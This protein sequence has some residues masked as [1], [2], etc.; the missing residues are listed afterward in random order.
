MDRSQQREWG[1]GIRVDVPVTQALDAWRRGRVPFGNALL[2]LVLLILVAAA[3]FSGCGNGK[4]SN[5]D[6]D[7][8]TPGDRNPIPAKLTLKEGPPL[9]PPT[10]LL[11]SGQGLPNEVLDAGFDK[12]GNLWAASTS[13]IFVRRHGLG[14][15][16]SFGSADGLKGE[17]VLSIGGG[18]ADTAWVG[19]RGEGDSDEDPEWM[20]MSGGVSR[21]ILDGA[22]IKV[23]HYNLI[24]PPGLYSSYPDGRHKLRTC[25]RTYP[26][27]NGP[28]A[29]DAWFGCNHGVGQVTAND[30]VWEHHHPIF[31]EWDPVRKDCTIRAGDVGAV[32]RTSNG[33]MWFG[34][35]Y[36]VMKL[37]YDDGARGNFWGAEP[38]RNTSL[39]EAPLSPNRHGSED[40]VGLGVAS[41]GTVWAASSHSGLARRH[42]NGDV[43]IYQESN[44]LPANRLED[45]AIDG[46]DGL[47]LAT[48]DGGVVRIDLRTGEWR[49]APGMPS[50][51]G[52]RV[53]FERTDVGDFVVA[54]VRGGI[55][56]W[57]R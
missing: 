52:R 9:D 57:K 54:V 14:A 4:G 29:G 8:T 19:Y 44:G 47:W 41:D 15:F 39:W 33:D 22:D 1:H 25:I 11:G 42:D 21:V 23:R 50:S 7:D 38:V 3:G 43:E 32:A 13:R 5:D 10:E 20:R 34:G 30:R 17:D 53:V 27:K 48:R 16:E 55:A 6:D 31:C 24:A 28:Y 45:L 12:S 35:A 56:V 36:G 46:D 49:R 26:T 2:T 51:L 37:S 40:V 18:L